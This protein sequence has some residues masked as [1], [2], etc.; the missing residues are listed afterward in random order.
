[1]AL[2]GPVGTPV[3][4]GFQSVNVR[5]RQTLD[6]LREPP[7]RQESSPRRQP[8]LRTW[9][10]SSSARTPK[11][12]TAGLEHTV[13]PGVVESLKIITEARLDAHR[14]VRLRVRAEARP[15]ARHGRPQ[16]QHHEALR[17]PVSRLLPAGG[18]GLSRTS[19]PT[20]ASSTPTCMRP[21]HEAREVRRP[22]P[23][24]ESLRRHRLG[25]RRRPRRRTRARP[26]RQPRRRTARSSRRSTAP[27]PTSPG[28]DKANPTALLMS[29]HPDAP[30]PRA[31]GAR[32]PDRTRPPRDVRAGIKTGDLGGTAGTRE[33]AKA[34]A[35]RRS[36]SSV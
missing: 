17:R 2:K 1:M 35:E 24:R 10:S 30:P 18:R 5:L 9:T 26:G 31:S 25:P 16:G 21:G 23:A 3:G 12:S 32:R 7:A 22:A 14:P 6:A 27:P 19:R 8:L 34:V 13:V 11:T 29:R 36:A 28:Q 20:T 15:Q 33:F 4:K